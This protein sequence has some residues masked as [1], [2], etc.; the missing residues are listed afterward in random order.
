MNFTNTPRQPRGGWLA[1]HPRK[2]AA[3]IAV[4]G[5]M[6]VFMVLPGDAPGTVNPTS[7]R[8][9]SPLSA[10]VRHRSLPDVIPFAI[11][12]DLDKRSKLLKSKKPAWFSVYKTGVLVRQGQSYNVTWLSEHDVITKHGEAG[13]GMELS[14]LIRYNGKVYTFDDRS[15][16]V[17][18][19]VH[20][21]ATTPRAYPR[22]ILMEGDGDTNKG[23]KIE[24]ATVK[25]GLLYTGS[26][27][28]EY[29]RADGSI[30][31]TNNMWV[32][33]ID[34]EGRIRHVDWT[35]NYVK[36]RRRMGCDFPG[37]LLHEAAVWSESWKK[38]LFFPR[39]MSKTAYE[40]IDDETRGT[41]IM[42]VADADFTQIDYR[43]ITTHVPERG[44]S[45]VKEVPTVDGSR[46]TAVVALRSAEDSR[47]DTQTTF[48]SVLGFDGTRLMAEVEIPGGYKYE[49]IELF[50]D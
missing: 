12:A 8:G 2:A 36:L 40:E 16:I 35:D 39:R 15:G 31:N 14:D 38:W 23:F 42:L 47:Q 3:I 49:G 1:Q 4:A 29:T 20:P 27:G 17:Y 50:M 30:E 24:W 9:T 6:F 37:Y 7:L 44:F 11:I 22:H 32:K 19:V 21:D 34:P 18:E 25:D 45:S 43:E 48:M 33:T 5:L 10:S 26:F 46:T 13:R 28:K 41:N